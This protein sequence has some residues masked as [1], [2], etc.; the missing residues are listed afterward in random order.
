MD[1]IYRRVKFLLLLLKLL[2]GLSSPCFRRLQCSYTQP[3][4]GRVTPLG[5]GKGRKAME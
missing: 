1:L 4:G 5:M 2:G 3:L